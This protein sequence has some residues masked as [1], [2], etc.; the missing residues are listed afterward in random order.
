MHNGDK[1]PIRKNIRLK[2]YDYSS[3]G[4]YFITS[5]TQDRRHL[6][7][8]VENGVMNLSRTG[9]IVKYCIEETSALRKDIL[10]DSY[11]IM[12]NHVHFILVNNSVQLKQK[13]SRIMTGIKS[14]VQSRVNAYSEQ[15]V[16]QRG[17]Y[18]HIIRDEKDL[19]ETRTYMENNPV[20]WTEDEY[21]K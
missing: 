20:K 2:Y 18:E 13:L 19:F 8:N 4:W 21:Y 6:F 1:V 12:P 11:T 5:C 15:K 7:G 3:S 16:W 10:V 14:S 9:K 17:Y